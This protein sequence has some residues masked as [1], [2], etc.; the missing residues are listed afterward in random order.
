MKP[1]RT[2]NPDDTATIQTSTIYVPA[3]TESMLDSIFYDEDARTSTNKNYMIDVPDILQMMDTQDT[4]PMSNTEEEQTTEETMRIPVLPMDFAQFTLEDKSSHHQCTYSDFQVTGSMFFD[5][6][7]EKC[8]T[9]TCTHQLHHVCS[10]NYA[11]YTYGED[12]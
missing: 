7:S 10:M 1:P 9:K 4:D 5:N 12:A 11:S 3:N 2:A 6:P 8:H